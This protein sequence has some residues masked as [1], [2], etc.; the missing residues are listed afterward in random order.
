MRSAGTGRIGIQPSNIKKCMRSAGRIRGGF[1]R[2]YGVKCIAS[3][4]VKITGPITNQ[5]SSEQSRYAMNTNYQ[6]Y[7]DK[8]IG[9]RGRSAVST[10]N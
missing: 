7:N 10:F 9:A 6:R 1:G 8:F 2:F 4:I 5:G 3:Q